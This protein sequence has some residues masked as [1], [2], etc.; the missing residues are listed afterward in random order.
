MALFKERNQAITCIHHIHVSVCNLWSKAHLPYI[1]SS[2]L[3]SFP[4]NNLK[5]G[6]LRQLHS[7]FHSWWMVLDAEQ[8][9]FLKPVIHFS[10]F[11]YTPFWAGQVEVMHLFVPCLNQIL[12]SVI[13]I[14]KVDF[15]IFFYIFFYIFICT[16]EIMFCEIYRQ[17]KSIL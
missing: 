3:D 13:T 8:V 5:K 2:S 6:Y 9:N 10:Y 15:C 1:R 14:L 11:Y 12:K 4:L 7:P 17:L 16:Y